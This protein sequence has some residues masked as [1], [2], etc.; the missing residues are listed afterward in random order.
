MKAMEEAIA[1]AVEACQRGSLEALEVTFKEGVTP[2]AC[3]ADGCS[4]LHWA[5][6]NNRIPVVAR[7]DQGF[8]CF[9]L[10]L[11]WSMPLPHR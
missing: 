3:D 8:Y 9:V 5:A 6:I 1:R 11:G 4:L 10:V 2:D 7:L